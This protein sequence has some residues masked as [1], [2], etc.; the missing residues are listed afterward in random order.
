MKSINNQYFQLLNQTLKSYKRAIPSLLVD[1]GKLDKNIETLQNS[2]HPSMDF[3]IVVKSL[4]SIPLIDY[5]L[6]KTASRKLMVFHQP[7]LAE[8]SSYYGD[9]INILMGK[10][11]PIQTAKYYYETLKNENRFEPSK[12]LQWLV[13]TKERIQ[14]YIKL[15]KTINQKIQLNIELDVGLH[16]GGF[17]DINELNEALKLIEASKENVEFCGFMGYDPHAVNL[18]KIIRTSAKA[19]QLSNDFYQNCIN[20]VK[21]Q[22]PTLWNNNLTFNGAG[23]PT[24]ALHQNE[25]S[26]LNDISAG[27]CLVKPTYFDIPTLEKYAAACFIATPILKKF[28]HTT[29]PVLESFKSLFSWLK[30]AF[31]QSYFI[32]G[33]YWK[34][35]YCYPEKTNEN[36]IFG[37]S[38]NQSMINTS[39]KIKLDVDDFI[40]L[41]PTQSEAVFLQFGNILVLRD[42]KIVD[43]WKVLRNN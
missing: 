7:F 35:D 43:E 19:F 24:L 11:M 18:P 37:S 21:E 17:S 33:G 8:L 28:E 1:L 26:V 10:P 12:Q 36:Q 34:A 40:F 29:L 20:L 3:R 25:T 14:Q 32:Y 38:T 30:P 31:R 27:S 15:A 23:S 22:F 39:S 41:R 6:N 4:P 5:I 16:R 13:D 42:G 9:D 2:I